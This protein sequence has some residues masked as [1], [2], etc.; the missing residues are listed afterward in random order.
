MI[1]DKS[2]EEGAGDTEGVDGGMAWDCEKDV[3]VPEG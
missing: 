1:W 2:Q 3:A